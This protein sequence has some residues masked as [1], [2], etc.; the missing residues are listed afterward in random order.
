MSVG[1]WSTRAAVVALVI[2]ACGD[3]HA[4]ARSPLERAIETTLTARLGIPVCAHCTGETCSAMA[5]DGTLIPISVTTTGHELE[6]HVDGFL[7]TSDALEA[8]V[9]EEVAE[10]GAPQGVTCARR[11]R[12]VVAG[13]RITCTLERGGRVFVTLRADGSLS[14]ETLLDPAAAKLRDELVTPELEEELA[15]ASRAL[16]NSEEAGED[17]EE[18]GSAGELLAPQAPR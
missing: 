1:A 11:I 2:A 8:Y 9:K 18:S 17:S 13:D 6:W 12:R 15:R 5:I 4:A 10:L 3:D 16:E 7:V 14:L